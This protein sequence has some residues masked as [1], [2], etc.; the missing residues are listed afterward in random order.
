MVIEGLREEDVRK[1]WE[2]CGRSV[3]GIRWHRAAQQNWMA[4]PKTRKKIHRKLEWENTSRTEAGE[5]FHQFTRLITTTRV[6]LSK[7]LCENS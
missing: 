5:L 6:N 7:I 2:K 3:E 4:F 1:S